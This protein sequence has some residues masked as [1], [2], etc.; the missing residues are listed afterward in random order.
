MNEAPFFSIVITTFRRPRQIVEC[1]HSLEFLDY[2]RSRYEVI[3]VDDGSPEPLD[4]IISSFRASLPLT[5]LRQP[6]G[7]PAS[8]RNTGARHARGRYLA[9][10]D[11]DC[12]PAPDWL[13]RLEACLLA[14][15]DIMVGGRTVNVLPSHCSAAS[16][17]IHDLVYGFFNHD[18]EHARFFATNNMALPRLQFLAAG[19]LDESFRFASEDR[20][21]CDRWHHLGFRLRYEPAATVC[22]RH[23]LNFPRFCRQHFAYGRGAAR[24]HAVRRERRSSSLLEQSI[25]HLRPDWWLIAPVLRAGGIID[26]LALFGLLLTWQSA[27]AAGYCYERLVMRPAGTASSQLDKP[28]VPHPEVEAARSMAPGREDKRKA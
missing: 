4:A 13:K 28:A 5:L 20:E 7:G 23:D 27:N 6:N 12:Q 24:F 15:P 10:T 9:F 21:L 14:D 1:L 26:G 25:F 3:V 17:I 16:Q 8:G 11:D 2:P 19:G 22:H 18:P